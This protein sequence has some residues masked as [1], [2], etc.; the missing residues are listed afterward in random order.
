M[1]FYL[2]CALGGIN[3]NQWQGMDLGLVQLRWQERIELEHIK[4]LTLVYAA[5]QNVEGVKGLLDK[6]FNLLDG[7]KTTETSNDPFAGLSEDGK[8]FLSELLENPAKFGPAK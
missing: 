7:D 6:Y 3:P 5:F 1:R 2:D 8:K 4:F